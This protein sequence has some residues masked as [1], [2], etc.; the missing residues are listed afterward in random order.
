M[1]KSKVGAH[2]VVNIR[3]G[4]LAGPSDAL[5]LRIAYAA[6]PDA[7]AGKDDV[8]DTQAKIFALTNDQAED[9]AAQLNNALR[10]IEG[11]PRDRFH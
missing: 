3:V 4:A 7:S 6:S 2:S 8:A 10:W 5:M 9:L 1:G 11:K